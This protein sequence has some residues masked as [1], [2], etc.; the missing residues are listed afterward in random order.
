MLKKMDKI[1]YNALEEGG[2]Y[3]MR[4]SE[5]KPVQ[6]YLQ[7][8]Q[9][10]DRIYE[11]YQNSPTLFT[12]FGAE[13]IVVI[14]D[15]HKLTL[16]VEGIDFFDYEKM[17]ENLVQLKNQLEAIEISN[18]CSEILIEMIQNEDLTVSSIISKIA[19]PNQTIKIEC[20]DTLYGNGDYEITV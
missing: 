15:T 9:D 12:V 5:F 10:F 6:N 14:A 11:S 17:E 2:V 3:Q 13:N 20:T 19:Q 7:I 1:L 8:L 4:T 16:V 18:E